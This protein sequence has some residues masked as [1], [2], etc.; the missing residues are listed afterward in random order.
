VRLFVLE[1]VRRCIAAGVVHGDETDIA[2]VLVALVQG[3]ALAENARRLGR[4][5]AAVDRRWALALDGLLDG[6]RAPPRP[7][8]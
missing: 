2:H 3:L 1:R 4:S 6:L 7:V 8:G 5:R